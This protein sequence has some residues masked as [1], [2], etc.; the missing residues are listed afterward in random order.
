MS[1]STETVSPSRSACRIRYR[2]SALGVQMYSGLIVRIELFENS[3]VRV[4]VVEV[5]Q[6]RAAVPR[7]AH[8]ADERG[9]AQEARQEVVLDVACH[10]PVHRRGVA[11]RHVDLPVRVRHHLV[12]DV[13]PSGESAGASRRSRPV[14]ITAG[15]AVAA[16]AALSV[17]GVAVAR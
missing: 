16:G 4:P 15:C 6:L 2:P 7:F 17:V 11:R 13:R 12:G 9:V 1:R 5:V 3:R 14:R 10:A 8:E